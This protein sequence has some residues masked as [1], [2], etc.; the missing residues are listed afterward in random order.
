MAAQM[1]KPRDVV[2]GVLV[3]AIGGGFLLLGTD[4]PT[5]TSRRMG[6]GYFPSMLSWL[7]V[8]LGAVIA[9]LALVRGA[10]YAGAVGRVPWRGL[11]LIIGSV[12]FFGETLRGIGLAPALFIVVLATAWASSYAS[13]RAS[14]PLA[15]GLAVFCFFLFI[16]GLG[17]PLPVIGPWLTFPRTAPVAD[18]AATAP[19]AAADPT[20]PA[21]PTP[22]PPPTSPPADAA[23]PPAATPPSPPPADVAPPEATPSASP[24][25]DVAPAPVPAPSSPPDA[26]PA[27]NNAPPPGQG[28]AAPAP[29]APPPQQQ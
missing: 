22:S 19:P 10:A 28:G 21:A 17:L 29:V 16:R 26:P 9:A 13:L 8:A 2:G 4:L 27:E 20:Q 1:V 15:I 6:A 25:A 14:I 3:M 11:L 24:P 7:L 12:I 18:P 5:G 23:P